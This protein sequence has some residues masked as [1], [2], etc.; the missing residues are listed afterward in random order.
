MDVIR[1]RHNPPW[2]DLPSCSALVSGTTRIRPY[3]VDSYRTTLSLKS[4]TCGEAVYRTRHGVYRIDAGSFLLLNQG[5]EYSMHISPG[6]PTQTL[7]PFF[8]PGLLEQASRAFTGDSAGQLDDPYRESRATDFCERLYPK[9]GRIALRLAKL[10]QAIQGD[11]PEG[12]LAD[13]F[14]GLAEDL[15]RLNVSV[16]HEQ[17]GF[18]GARPATRAEMYRRLYRARDYIE[19]CFAEPMTVSQI[20]RAASLSPFHFQRVFK[21]AFGRTPMQY[22]QERRLLVAKRLLATTDRDITAICFDVGF[23]SLGSFS[24]LFRR[25]VGTSPRGFRAALLAH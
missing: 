4:V 13:Q 22:L 21:Q 11:I 20:A 25:R 15:V 2:R 3:H 9:D 8:Q 18:P 19:S 23:E 17:N 12:W 10:Q 24:W 16:R 6:C 1:F 5:Q 14:F 7:C